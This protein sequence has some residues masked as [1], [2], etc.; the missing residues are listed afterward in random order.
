MFITYSAQKG[1]VSGFII[2]FTRVML[3]IEYLFFVVQIGLAILGFV[4]AGMYGNKAQTDCAIAPIFAVII[5]HGVIRML[6][7]LASLLQSLIKQ[8]KRIGKKSCNNFCRQD[9]RKFQIRMGTVWLLPLLAFCRF[10]SHAHLFDSDLCEAGLHRG[11]GHRV[12]H[13][14]HG[15]CC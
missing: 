3:V 11:N 12:S 6:G 14:S 15:N 5:A 4:C 13:R 9:S 2:Y 10:H 7:A 1:T 8:F